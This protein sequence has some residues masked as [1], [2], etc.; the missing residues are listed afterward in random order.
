MEPKFKT[1]DAFVV[2]GLKY[3]GS[4]DNNEIPKLWNQ[5]SK[6]VSL[7]K[8]LATEPINAYGICHSFDMDKNEFDY[9]AGLEVKND[10]DEPLGM[11]K[12]EVPKQEYAVFETTLPNIMTTINNIY[13]KWLPSSDYARTEGPEFEYYDK[14]FDPEKEDS[15][16]S[17]YVPVKKK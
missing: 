13:N 5:F 7:I 6:K 16:L 1:K 12:F 3:R 14:D 10:S 17:I 8:P 15:T 11:V 2:I 4:N 9:I